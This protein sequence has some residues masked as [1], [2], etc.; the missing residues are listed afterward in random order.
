MVYKGNKDLLL[1][2]KKYRNLKSI[3]EFYNKQ[4]KMFDKKR[5]KK[6]ILKN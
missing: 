2:K 3:S 5:R 1:E 4:N 6:H